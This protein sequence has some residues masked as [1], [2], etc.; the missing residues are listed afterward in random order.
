MVSLE[1]G[2]RRVSG[3]SDPLTRFANEQLSCIVM[4]EPWDTSLSWAD[5]QLDLADVRPDERDRVIA[6]ALLRLHDDQLVHFHEIDGLVG[7]WPGPMGE[8]PLDRHR[9]VEVLAAGS[10][11]ATDGTLYVPYLAM[12][13][14]ENGRELHFSSNPADRERWK[15][16]P[17]LCREGQIMSEPTETPDENVEAD[18]AED[19]LEDVSGGTGFGALPPEINSG[20]IYSGPGSTPLP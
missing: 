18:L 4:D 15:P 7:S 14:T 8:Q 12:L 17:F 3:E 20:R 2:H 6:D 5:A 1:S 11:A 9:L 13:S 16:A 19:E 10:T